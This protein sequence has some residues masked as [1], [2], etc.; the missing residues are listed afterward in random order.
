MQ[1]DVDMSG[2]GLQ[3]RK[4]LAELAVLSAVQRM[5]RAH[6]YQMVQFFQEYAGLEFTEATVYPLLARLAREECLA[7]EDVESPAGPP[8]RVYSITPKGRKQLDAMLNHWKVVCESVSSM[9]EVEKTT[10]K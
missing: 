8:R 1:H 2:W 5:K 4:G 3:I 9:T 6:G 10:G 7:V